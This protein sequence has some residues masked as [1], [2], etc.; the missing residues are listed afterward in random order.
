MSFAQANLEHANDVAEFLHQRDAVA[1]LY[2]CL[3]CLSCTG[4]LKQKVTARD[5]ADWERE[6]CLNELVAQVPEHKPEGTRHDVSHLLASPAL[7]AA[8]CRDVHVCMNHLTNILKDL[9]NPVMCNASQQMH[10]SLFTGVTR[11]LAA[12]QQLVKHEQQLYP[13]LLFRLLGPDGE[14]AAEEIIEDRDHSSNL[15]DGITH[16]IVSKYNTKQLLLSEPCLAQI[17]CIA[18]LTRESTNQ[19]ER[20]H[21]LSKRNAKLQA[22]SGKAIRVPELSALRFLRAVDKGVGIHAHVWKKKVTASKKR[23]AGQSEAKAC[24]RRRLSRWQAWTSCN[25]SG[26]KANKTDALHYNRPTPCGDWYMI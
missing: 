20:G 5:G 12:M 22:D 9:Q 23:P 17:S 2:G 6:M 3:R 18:R 14:H 25:V 13:Y 21:S 7:V 4:E 1:R 10:T 15:F 24:K 19:I 26:R 8:E 16:T 11:G